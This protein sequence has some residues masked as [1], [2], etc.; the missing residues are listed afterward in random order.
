M[1]RYIL[2]PTIRTAWPFVKAD[3]MAVE[4]TGHPLKLYQFEASKP[5]ELPEAGGRQ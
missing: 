5:V 1:F 3:I 4:P 2:Y